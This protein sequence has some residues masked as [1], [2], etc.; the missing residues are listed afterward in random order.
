MIGLEQTVTKR[1]TLF[2]C[3]VSASNTASFICLNKLGKGSGGLTGGTD[4][5]AAQV[6]VDHVA[7]PGPYREAGSEGHH[8]AR[9]HASLGTFLY[10]VHDATPRRRNA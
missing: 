9:A 4:T 3:S 1:L 7:H 2:I 8:S 10:R 6:A 5:G